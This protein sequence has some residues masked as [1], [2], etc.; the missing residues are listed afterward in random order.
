MLP[1]PFAVKPISGFEF[2]HSKLLP[3][4]LPEN[5]IVNGVVPQTIVSEVAD[6]EGLGL[7]FI[8]KIFGVPLQLF[9]VGVTVI[10]AV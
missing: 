6:T 1:M 2:V 10:V 5:A 9:N 4:W 8:L 7:T 3:A